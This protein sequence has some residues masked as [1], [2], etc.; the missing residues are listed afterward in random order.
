MSNDPTSQDMIN[1]ADYW[2]Q[3]MADSPDSLS[4]EERAE[5]QA[6]L[7]ASD[8]NQRAFR[9]AVALTQMPADLSPAK[10]HA[11]ISRSA[12]THSE[13]DRIAGRRNIL[14]FTGLAASVAALLVTGTV[15]LRQGFLGQT[16]RTATGETQTVRFSDGSVAYLNTRT[17]LRWVGTGDE[18]VVELVSG[19]ALFDVVH[20]TKRPFRVLLDGSEIRVLGTR[21]N[22]YRKSGG[23]V[24]LTVLEGTVEA[25]GFGGAGSNPEW[26]RRV[27]AHQQM[28]YRP[29]GLVGEPQETDPLVAVKWREGFFQ[30]PAKGAPLEAVLDELTRYTDKN[31]VIRDTRVA[32]L[33]VSGAIN[34][35]DVRIALR[36]LQSSLPVN[37]RETEGAYTLD[38]RESSKER[39]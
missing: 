3:R 22:V 11:L 36:N 9:S 13:R 23:D 29:I 24:V 1:P 19:E 17:E 4:E 18:R 14:K 25:R 27:H 32:T 26:V 30:L 7:L 37:V 20:D 6:W 10:Q 16:H 5:F 39:N 33:N 2:A 15:F 8:E 35:R 38:Y 34:T 31:I 28:Q 12:N 21:F